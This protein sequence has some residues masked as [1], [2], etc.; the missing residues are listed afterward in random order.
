[1]LTYHYQNDLIPTVHIA[2]MAKYPNRLLPQIEYMVIAIATK[3]GGTGKTTTS[4]SLA[5]GLARLHDKK[6]LLI[7]IDSQVCRK[8]LLSLSMNW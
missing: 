3:K 7:D 2:P 8:K 5:V 1:M 4:I 6:I